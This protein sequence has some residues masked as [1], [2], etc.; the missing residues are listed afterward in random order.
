[1]AANTLIS[2]EIPT[3][4]LFSENNPIK[5]LQEQLK[6]TRHEYFNA[7]T[8]KE[9]LYLQQQDKEIRKKIAAQIS[10]TLINKKE[11]EIANL[12]KQLEEA[13]K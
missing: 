1:M 10:D 3:T 4:D 9:K 7:K 12:E 5:L 13:K 2:L 6:A 8:R 11:K